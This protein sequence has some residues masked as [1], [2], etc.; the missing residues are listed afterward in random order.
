MVLVAMAVIVVMVV[1]MIIK[2]VLGALKESPIHP[3]LAT[4]R[5]APSIPA[6][7]TTRKCP[8]P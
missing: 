2:V 7:P 6:P 4:H 3:D 5:L 1:V 8:V